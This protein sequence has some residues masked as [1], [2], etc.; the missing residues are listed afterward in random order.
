M[1]P[2]RATTCTS[3]AHMGTDRKPHRAYACQAERDILGLQFSMRCHEGVPVPTVETGA[4]A[5]C[6]R[7]GAQG[8]HIDVHDLCA[9]TLAELHSRAS[10]LGV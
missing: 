6:D 1:K 2:G 7:E 3:S 9:A 10:P 5:C 8:D 4:V